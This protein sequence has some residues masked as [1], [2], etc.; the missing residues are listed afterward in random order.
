MELE[1]SIYSPTRRRKGFRAIASE[2]AAVLSW[3][4]G[5]TLAALPWFP[6][7][8]LI[9]FKIFLNSSSPWS[10]FNISCFQRFF[11]FSCNKLRSI[12][13][14]CLYRIY[15][16]PKAVSLAKICILIYWWIGNLT[17]YCRSGFGSV[18]VWSMNLLYKVHLISY[19]VCTFRL[20]DLFVLAFLD[21]C[22]LL[23]YG[24][25]CY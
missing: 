20:L 11:S 4:G 7:D 13:T 23:N 5:K 3:S 9:L 10:G 22:S 6:R 12:Y 1:T 15:L 8:V 21:L 16:R 2:V 17:C 18:S 14:N 25:N 19:S 24:Y